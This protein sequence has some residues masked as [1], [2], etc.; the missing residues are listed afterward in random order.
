MIPGY[1]LVLAG[2][3]GVY[4]YNSPLVVTAALAGVALLIALFI[5]IRKPLSRHH[6]AFIFVGTLLLTV[7]G[8]LHYFPQF[9]Y[10]T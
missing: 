3:G 10:G 5:F 1:L 6:G 8:T 7:F 4:F 2:A 9:Q